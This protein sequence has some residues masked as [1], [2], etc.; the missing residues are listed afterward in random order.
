MHIR[1]ERDTHR[2][3]GDTPSG[4]AVLAYV[5]AGAGAL[6]LYSTYVPAAERGQGL[7]AELVQAA[8]TYAREQGLRIVPTCWYV[9]DWLGA[10]PEHRDLV[11][12]TP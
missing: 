7:G 1:H 3:L 6:E 5:P 10:H 9:A 12:R 11:L 8:V 4:T 2:F